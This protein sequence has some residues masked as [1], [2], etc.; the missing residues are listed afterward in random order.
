MKPRLTQSLIADLYS[1]VEIAISKSGVVNIP[2]LAQ[3]VQ[4]RNEQDNVALEDIAEELMRVAQGR[5]VAME[6]DA[7][8]AA[9]H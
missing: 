5:G 4:V 6:F 7:P 9:M 8:L 3:Q 2:L 1:T